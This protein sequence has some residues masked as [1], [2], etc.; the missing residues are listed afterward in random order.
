MATQNLSTTE[1]DSIVEKIK[2]LLAL[3]T[4]ANEHEAGRAAQKAQELAFRYELELSTIAGMGQG[5]TLEYQSHGICLGDGKMLEWRRDLI[6]CLA[7]HNFCRAFSWSGTNKMGIVGQRH[8]FEIVMGL[9]D[10]L[11]ATLSRL[12]ERSFVTYKMAGGTDKATAYKNSWL[13]GAVVGIGMQL[14]EQRKADA[15]SDAGSAL[16]VVKDAELEDAFSSLVGKTSKHQTSNLN[17]AAGFLQGRETGKS[18]S[19][20]AQVKGSNGQGVKALN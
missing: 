16:V 18:I 7:R 19:L 5:Q 3:S 10:Y 6:W 14:A 15:S 9:Y 20:N 4:S 13:R 8:N 17:S 2:K 11:S 12:V 1:L